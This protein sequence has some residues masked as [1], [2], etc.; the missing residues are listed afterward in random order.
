MNFRLYPFQNYT[1]TTT[2]LLPLQYVSAVLLFR[3][4][5]ERRTLLADL[6]H[7]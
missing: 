5:D 2:L 4:T 7:F 6:L 3:E 1:L